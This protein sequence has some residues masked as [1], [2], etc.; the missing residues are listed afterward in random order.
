M[1]KYIALITN[2]ETGKI[3]LSS[4][5]EDLP[6]IALNVV[7]DVQSDGL[8]EFT[9]TLAKNGDA[10]NVLTFTS[11]YEFKAGDIV[12]VDPMT[13]GENP[14]LVSEANLTE[15]ELA[16]QMESVNLVHKY[17]GQLDNLVKSLAM[18][19]NTIHR[20]N[21]I[22]L[23]GGINFFTSSDGSEIN[24]RNITVNQA[25]LDDVSLVNTGLTTTSPEGDGSRALAIAQLRNGRYSINDIDNFQT[26][27]DANYNQS[28]MTLNSTVT[29]TAFDGY[30]KD[31]VAKV[32]IDAQ[33]VQ[34]GLENQQ[35][36][37]LQYNQRRESISGV[38]IDE[39]VANLVQ[40]QTAYQANAK[41]MSTITIMLDTLINRMG[42]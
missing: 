10:N 31:I 3:L 11:N 17:E 12:F 5:P 6:E 38:S 2:N 16:G 7:R 42:I 39:E 29:G 24:A 18:S 35:N 37:I 41:V 1:I 4:N 25:I 26:Y 21:G 19:I 9:I 23:N 8:G 34:R 14:P 13:W 36:L 15:G 20:D 22:D 27:I 30:Y 32:G 33:V 40:L 28:S